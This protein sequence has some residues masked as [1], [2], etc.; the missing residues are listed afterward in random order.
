MLNVVMLNVVMLNVVML[1]VLAPALAFLSNV[2]LSSKS[3]ALYKRSSVMRK[4]ENKAL[5]H[6]HP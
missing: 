6:R 5:K 2:R 4:G 1:S 3:L